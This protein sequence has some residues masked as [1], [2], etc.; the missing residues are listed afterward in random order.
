MSII[1]AGKEFR[2]LSDEFFANGEKVLE[3]WADGVKVYPD[4]AGGDKW[5][6]KFRGE[7]DGNK[8]VIAAVASRM[9]STGSKNENW[10]TTAYADCDYANTGRPYLTPDIPIAHSGDAGSCTAWMHYEIGLSMNGGIPV[11]L[12]YHDGIVVSSQGYTGRPGFYQRVIDGMYLNPVTANY[13]HVPYGRNATMV[14]LEA[15][16]APGNGAGRHIAFIPI[17]EVVYKNFERAYGQSG[18]VFMERDRQTPIGVDK[19]PSQTF[20]QTKPVASPPEWAMHVYE[21]DFDF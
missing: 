11:I 21:S 3:A 6:I 10:I 9:L 20:Y 15:R 2:T 17:T 12:G 8:F 16:T 18:Y 1:V 14:M 5:V 13:L 7:E 4:D 19:F